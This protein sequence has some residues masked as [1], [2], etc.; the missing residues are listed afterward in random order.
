MNQIKKRKIKESLK[1]K[2]PLLV[3][4]GSFLVIGLVAMFIGFHMT[5]WSIVKWLQSPFAATTF[6]C[7]GAGILLF[8][9]LIVAIKRAQIMMEK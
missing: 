1:K 3:G 4:T 8:A 2:W 7:L 9:F 6:I 5:G